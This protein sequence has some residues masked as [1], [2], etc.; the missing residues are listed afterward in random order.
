MVIWNC[1][2][3]ATFLFSCFF[4]QKRSPRQPF[5]DPGQS[6]LHV[7]WNLK[8]LPSEACCGMSRFPIAGRTVPGPPTL[9]RQNN[10]LSS[11]ACNATEKTMIRTRSKISE[12]SLTSL[13][14]TD[15]KALCY[16]VKAQPARWQMW[17]LTD[18]V[19]ETQPNKYTLKNI[20]F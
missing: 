1:W 10:G 4:G 6:P 18:I 15:Y 20:S 2:K 19:P 13:R 16:C 14:S 12:E 9:W 7:A 5:Q 17:R 8:N 11:D 3:Y